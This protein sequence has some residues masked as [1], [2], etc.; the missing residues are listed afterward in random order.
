MTL[1][2]T[3]SHVAAPSFL[4][5]VG[6]VTGVIIVLPA[7]L[8]LTGFMIGFYIGLKH[9]LHKSHA[10]ITP[11]LLVGFLGLSGLTCC[12]LEWLTISVIAMAVQGFVGGV[13]TAVGFSTVANLLTATLLGD[14]T[15]RPPRRLP[16]G[17]TL[18]FGPGCSCS[19]LTLCLQ[20][21]LLISNHDLFDSL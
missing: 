16:F 15:S 11:I 20:P 10:L 6:T 4:F 12:S 3:K 19:S 17:I 1:V 21:L 9:G 18:S 7:L 5:T 14:S 8:R 13:R 2:Y